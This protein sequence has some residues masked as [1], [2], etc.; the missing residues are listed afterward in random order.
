MYNMAIAIF[1]NDDLSIILITERS[2]HMYYHHEHLDQYGTYSESLLEL[3]IE[4]SGQLA[5]CSNAQQLLT[6]GQI[7]RVL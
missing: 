5:R 6:N 3:S 1:A 4:S 7:V 2:D